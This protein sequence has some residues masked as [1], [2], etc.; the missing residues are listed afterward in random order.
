MDAHDR[1]LQ[2][3]RDADHWDFLDRPVARFAA[4]VLLALMIAG[5]GMLVHATGGIKYVYSHAMYLPIIVA[6]LMFRTP[7]GVLAG[8]IGGLVLGP[9]MPIDTVTGEPQQTLNWLY[10]A[11]FFCM[12]GGLAG[13]LFAAMRAQISRT[14]WMSERNVHTGLPNR[15]YLER[16]LRSALHR[17]TLAPEFMVIVVNVDNYLEIINTLSPE[18]SQPLMMAVYERINAR[19]P[20]SSLLCQY[21]NDRFVAITRGDDSRATA[22]NITTALRR[23]FDVTGIHVYVDASIGIAQFPLHGHEPEELIQKASI[24]MHASMKKGRPFS[25]YDT[26]SDQSNRETMAL[27][28][29]IPDAVAAGEFR[30]YCQ[31]KLRLTDRVYTG[32][33][34][35]MRWRHPV[36]GDIPPGHFIPHAERTSLIHLLTGWALEETFKHLSQWRVQIPGIQVAVNLTARDIGDPDLPQLINRLTR[37]YALQPDTIE[38]E[39][40]ETGILSDWQSAAE[41][42][43]LIKSHGFRIAIDDFGTGQS[44]LQYL[45]H[46]PIDTLKID[47]AFIKNLSGDRRDQTIVKTVIAMAHSLGLEVT[48]EG[49]ED[50]PAIEYLASHGCTHAQGYAIAR[51]FPAQ[52]LTSWIQSRALH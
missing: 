32:A 36:R 46:L 11:F 39:I 52:E 14:Q 40:T 13:Y 22:Q 44:S 26:G 18:I 43:N 24:A 42:L 3:L 16:M 7:G 17:K 51:P 35:L 27:L 41:L 6:G 23:S 37:E 38:F 8:I 30:L 47:Q 33:E 1:L 49:V 45:K 10:R 2:H 31:P 50:L 9:Y 29:L 4:L 34:V 28:G 15:I 12:V 25:I 48:A 5:V 19:L 20:P 21:H